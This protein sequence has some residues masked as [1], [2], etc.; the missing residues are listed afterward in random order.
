MRLSLSR[1]VRSSK[2]LPQWILV[3]IRMLAEV[4]HFLPLE[5]I[6]QPVWRLPAGVRAAAAILGLAG[7]VGGVHVLDAQIATKGIPP[8]PEFTT[9]IPGTAE[10]VPA[11]AVSAAGNTPSEAPT[12][13]IVDRVPQG[14]THQF[15]SVTVSAYCVGSGKTA[16]SRQVR[17]GTVALSRDL[18]R[19]FTPSAPYS[20]GDRILIPGMGM[21]VVE[22]AMNPRWTRKADIWFENEATARRWGVRNVYITRVSAGEPLLVSSKW[23]P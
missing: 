10:N 16:S 20:Y 6:A 4:P 5:E 23:N 3:H 17:P 21:Y 14:D 7:L 19:N 22:D 18:L 15:I 8:M 1:T 13:L 11:I 9:T 12:A 2:A